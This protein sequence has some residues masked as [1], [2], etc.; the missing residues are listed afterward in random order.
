MH[1]L[2]D[3]GATKMRIARAGSLTQFDTPRIID[4]PKTF[5]EGVH[6]LIET[7]KKIAGD[8]S[9][10]SIAGGVTGS[11]SPDKRI[12]DVSPHLPLWS[13][14]SIVAELEQAFHV[15]VFTENDCTMVGLGEAH[16]GAGAGYPIVAYITVSTGVG[17]IRLINGLP[18]ISAH[19]FEPGQQII[20][21]DNSLYPEC[22]MPNTL[23]HAVS[24]TAVEQRF[25]KKP[26]DIPQ[27]D[28]LWEQLA[29]WLAIGL[30]NLTVMWSPDVIVLGGSMMVG[31]P[32]IPITRVR[33]K[34]KGSVA[35]FKH[36]PEIKRAELGA[37]GGI[38]GALIYLQKIVIHT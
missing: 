15:P 35:I 25:G 19:G 31:N 20:D 10:V 29:D 1:I 5:E 14:R 2:F 6:L 34:V 26:Y 32:A 11:L 17:G 16:V 38:H 33:D 30:A 4:T 12:I 24:G 28:T 18:D 23:E 7:A 22:P 13:G 27:D 37:I 8:E 36:L 9:I 3:I 21:A